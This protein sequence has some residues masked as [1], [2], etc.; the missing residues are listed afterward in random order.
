MTDHEPYADDRTRESKLR[1]PGL[2]LLLV[3]LGF[4]ALLGIF[5]APTTGK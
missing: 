2:S 4:G 1:G 3:G 5:L